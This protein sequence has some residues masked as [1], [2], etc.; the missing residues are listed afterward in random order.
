MIYISNLG[1]HFGHQTLF[2]NVSFQLNRANR[3]GLVGANGSGKSTLL[4]I[5]SGE[6]L[7]ESGEVNYPSSLKFGILKV[8]PLEVGFL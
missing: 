6:I 4:K 1:M 3:Y 5:L 7:P 2:D 8:C